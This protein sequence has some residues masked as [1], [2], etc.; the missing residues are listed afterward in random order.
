M[1]ISSATVR[2]TAAHTRDKLHGRGYGEPL[3]T[4]WLVPSVVHISDVMKLLV[5][6][7]G[8]MTRSFR[9]MCWDIDE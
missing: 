3:N 2:A 1:L 6:F 7:W 8:V 5:I 9:D 4:G